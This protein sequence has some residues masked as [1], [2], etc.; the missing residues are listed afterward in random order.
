MLEM[1]NIK[2]IFNDNNLYCTGLFLVFYFLLDV[3]VTA[4]FVLCGLSLNYPVFLAL[5]IAIGVLAT[6]RFSA[7]R[8]PVSFSMVLT[9]SL[10]VI[11]CSMLLT[12]LFFDYSFDGRIHFQEPVIQLAQGWNSF[13]TDFKYGDYWW[14]YQWVQAY[15]LG[16]QFY[17]A[18]IYKVFG[19][20]YANSYTFLLL[21]ASFLTVFPCLRRVFPFWGALCVTLVLILFPCT[22]AQLWSFYI[23]GFIYSLFVTGM[24]CLSFFT[25]AETKSL[26]YTGMVVVSGIIIF[27]PAFKISCIMFSGLLF[28]G[29]V[30]LCR[31]QWR[32]LIPFVVVLPTLLIV[33]YKPYLDHNI[34]DLMEVVLFSSNQSLATFFDST[35]GPEAYFKNMFYNITGLTYGD[36][37]F[38]GFF[39]SKIYYDYSLGLYSSWWVIVFFITLGYSL[40]FLRKHKSFIIWIL[41]LII[42]PMAVPSLINQRYYPLPYLFPFIIFIT[43]YKDKV[44]PKFL[45]FICAVLMLGHLIYL[46]SGLSF[47]FAS[48]QAATKFISSRLEMVKSTPGDFLYVE[49][50][51]VGKPALLQEA[52]SDRLWLKDID[53]TIYI[54]NHMVNQR[55]IEERF[56]AGKTLDSVNGIET[57][58]IM[59]NLKNPGEKPL[60]LKAK[61]NVPYMNEERIIIYLY[62]NDDIESYMQKGYNISFT[63]LFSR[64]VKSAEEDHVIFELPP[65]AQQIEL[66]QE[67]EGLFFTGFEIR[68]VEIELP[69]Y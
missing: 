56:A 28:L 12:G 5:I 69:E 27:Y 35:W 52:F 30:W 3:L 16:I 18:S 49:F 48:N 36:S 57:N 59:I 11:V 8:L 68:E 21:S 29:Y 42:L 67:R 66:S 50:T 62:L 26:K 31:K 58:K 7:L 34:F 19:M 1:M 51:N 2:K 33:D 37:L 46:L 54:P 13:T 60:A 41:L 64:D 65:Y 61:F 17:S 4:I 14:G 25:F 24:A 40:V 44:F 32:Y 43:L 23:D 47:T 39:V 63:T 6:C 20:L 9:L 53:K 15:P 10:V 22:V 45:I 55:S 38:S